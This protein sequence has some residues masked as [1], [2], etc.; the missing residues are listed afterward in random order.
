[1]KKYSLFKSLPFELDKIRRDPLSE[2][3]APLRNEE[4]RLNMHAKPDA[5]AMRARA[6][7]AN[8]RVEGGD[9]PS[10]MPKLLEHNFSVLLKIDGCQVDLANSWR[11]SADVALLAFKWYAL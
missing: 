4:P 6:Q 11:C 7:R 2:R 3:R 5:P 9:L 8:M 10:C 1:V